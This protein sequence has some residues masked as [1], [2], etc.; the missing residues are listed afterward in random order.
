MPL[1]GVRSRWTW[2]A[3]SAALAIEAA[4]SASENNQ[5]GTV[6][7]ALIWQPDYVVPC[8]FASR[9]A[10]LQLHASIPLGQ[11]KALVAFS[12]ASMTFVGAPVLLMRNPPV[13][14]LADDD[15]NDALLL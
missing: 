10:H 12:S 14:L 8:T 2:V 6:V 7:A 3:V 13:I 9:R 1:S 15:D 5:N 4:K 11:G